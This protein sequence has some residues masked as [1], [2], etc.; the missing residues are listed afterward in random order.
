MLD[1]KMLQ[2]DK[3]PTDDNSL[4]MMSKALSKEKLVVCP[5]IVSPRDR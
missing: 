3:I 5:E 1:S 2:L 4:D